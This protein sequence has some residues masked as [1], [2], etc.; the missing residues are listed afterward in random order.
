MKPR[1]R[2]AMLIATIVLGGAA[3]VSAEIAEATR[4]KLPD[5]AAV[6]PNFAFRP[7]N[8]GFSEARMEQLSLPDGFEINVFAKDLGNARILA[9]DHDGTVYLSCMKE[10]KVMALRDTSGDG[11]A[12]EV[13]AVFE[14]LPKVHGLALNDEAI[15]MAAP[16]ILWRAARDGDGGFEDPEVLMDDLPDGGQ[17]PNRT[18]G[19]GPDGTLYLS[20]GSTCNACEEPNP[21]HATILTIS[22]DR[23]S[24]TVFAKGLRNTIGFGWHP[25][26]GTFWGMDHGSDGRGNDVPPEELNR[27][28]EGNH[29]GWPWVFGKRAIDPI[30]APPEEEGLSKEEFA[31][32]TTPMEL[33]HQAHSAPMEMLFYTGDQFPDRFR[34]GAFVAFRGSWN[35]V[36]PVGYKVAFL[37]FDGNGNPTEFEDFLT[38]FLMENGEAHFA[39][40]CGLTLADDGSLLVSDDANGV[41]YRV[42]Y[43]G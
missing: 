3:G 41:V 5:G 17:H 34:N 40:L 36:P 37:P 16:T 15:Y 6:E 25:Q 35:R 33:G 11:V 29:Y 30:S 39:R 8:K 42:S 9:T 2:Y 21:E 22:D 23:R 38:G 32:R 1:A 12:D 28:E 13:T 18:L 20:V 14:D 10:G 31:A 7:E 27:I 24:R 19:F 26:T 43:R 4:E